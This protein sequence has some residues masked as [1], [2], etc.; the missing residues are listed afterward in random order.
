[1]EYCALLL[2]SQRLET[3]ADIDKGPVEFKTSMR[4]H[5]DNMII[6]YG[7]DPNMPFNGFRFIRPRV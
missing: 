7:L 5:I 2:V 1:M 4:K 3:E 6:R